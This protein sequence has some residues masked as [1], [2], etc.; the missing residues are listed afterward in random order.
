[1]TDFTNYGTLLEKET[2]T[3]LTYAE[4]G[5]VV[6]IDFPEL[7]QES[8]ETTNHSTGWRTFISGGLKEVTE[9]TA[10]V[11]YKGTETFTA[12]W[13]AGTVGNYRITYPN[14]KKWSFSALIT[15]VKPGSAD[16]A[17]PEELTLDVTFQ[18]SG[19]CTLA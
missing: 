14:A 6:N 9:F 19:E 4:I 17:S 12:D 15:K 8:I 7:V 13:E 2:G 5:S 10:T 18:P 3:P 16:A 11:S 1:M